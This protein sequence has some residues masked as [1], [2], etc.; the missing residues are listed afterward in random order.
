MVQ[1]FCVFL[2]FCYLLLLTSCSAH[3]T[4]AETSES[5]IAMAKQ[6]TL[7][8][9]VETPIPG[10]ADR[11]EPSNS[12]ATTDVSNDEG[13]AQSASESALWLFASA[14]QSNSD[15]FINLTDALNGKED[16]MPE[17]GV[18]DKYLTPSTFHVFQISE[19]GSSV[20]GLN[21]RNYEIM[22]LNNRK[23]RDFQHDIILAPDFN[24]YLS[25]DNDQWYYH[26]TLDADGQ[27]I[28]LKNLSYFENVIFSPDHHEIVYSMQD[29]PAHDNAFVIY[30]L[31]QKKV[32]KEVMMPKLTDKE[33]HSAE[34]GYN[35]WVSQWDD[36][37]ILYTFHHS[38]YKYD[39]ESGKTEKL[40]DMMFYPMFL[41]PQQLLYSKPRYDPNENDLRTIK[42]YTDYGLYIRDLTNNKD[43]LIAPSLE[44]L[45]IIPE[46]LVNTSMNF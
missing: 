10:N 8:D 31:E 39:V 32:L 43:I 24:S 42:G 2:L 15:N 21:H 37:E 26:Q 38:T 22:N 7:K 16:V 17:W 11:Q 5:G 28:Q 34:R 29:V 1:K 13:G 44:D 41:N 45:D 9:G 46:Q 20:Y 27:P 25:F 33:L 35:V 36:Y 4:V 40:G 18:K 14:F 23:V 12:P 30:D 6:M 3:S 19:D